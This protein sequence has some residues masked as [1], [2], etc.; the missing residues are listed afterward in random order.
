MSAFIGVF[1]TSLLDA[2]D[3][4]R[5]ITITDESINSFGNAGEHIS[6]S[7]WAL[8]DVLWVRLIPPEELGRS[9]GAM[10][11][12]T[13]RVR[14]RVG[15]PASMSMARIADVLHA[16]GIRVT[17]AGWEPGDPEAGRRSDIGDDA[18]TPAAMPAASARVERLGEGKPGGS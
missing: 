12:L 8:R 16:Q 10:D 17:L 15:V 9:F 11:F 5:Q 1:L 2:P 4:N 6:M 18:P 14:A 13:R 3:L 7:T